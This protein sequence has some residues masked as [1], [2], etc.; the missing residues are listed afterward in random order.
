MSASEKESDDQSQFSEQSALFDPEKQ[1]RV[2]E[3]VQKLRE[4][5]QANQRIRAFRNLLQK[6]DSDKYISL[7]HEK[8]QA[9]PA[10][11][12]DDPD[13]ALLYCYFS[14]RYYDEHM[15]KVILSM[16]NNMALAAPDV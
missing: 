14:I 3:R 9:L 12:K 16:T 8:M 2:R 10:E 1:R 4:K 11:L 7:S 5:N 6:K 15:Y 13:E